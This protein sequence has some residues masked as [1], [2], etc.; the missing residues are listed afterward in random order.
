[1]VANQL[2]D[3]KY[4]LNDPSDQYEVLT[5]I[6]NLAFLV[7]SVGPGNTSQ[8]S[9]TFIDPTTN[10]TRGPFLLYSPDPFEI[11]GQI[12][13]IHTS[14]DYF[15]MFLVQEGN[16]QSMTEIKFLRNGLVFF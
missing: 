11:T 10:S 8:S 14:S 16:N 4:S 3:G 12:C 7:N 1:M 6:G 2:S 9:V 15:C 5:G 13:D